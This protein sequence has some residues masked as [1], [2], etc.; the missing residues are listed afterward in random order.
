MAIFGRNR[1]NEHMSHR[2]AVLTGTIAV[3]I[4]V[5]TPV[6]GQVRWSQPRT[7]DGQ[8]DLQGVWSNASL[9]PLERPAE[10]AGRE[11]LTEKEVAAKEKA[12]QPRKRESA[13]T[14]AHYDFLQ[15]GLDPLQATRA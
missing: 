3:L 8:P 5:T 15:Y 7:P 10:F 4:A 13:G 6:N 12:L 11:F 2:L 1:A 9:T 14:E